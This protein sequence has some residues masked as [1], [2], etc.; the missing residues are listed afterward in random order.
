MTLILVDVL[1]E[2]GDDTMRVGEK[3]KESSS[4]DS[5]ITG[6]R[7]FVL[8]DGVATTDQRRA[9]R[10]GVVSVWKGTWR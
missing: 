8:R 10:G 4:N 3:L 6:S 2:L 9:G 1:T 5:V 7:P